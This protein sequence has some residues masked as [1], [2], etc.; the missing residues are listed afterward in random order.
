LVRKIRRR[1]WRRKRKSPRKKRRKMVKRAYIDAFFDE[2]E[3]LAFTVK[4]N[5][6]QWGKSKFETGLQT[7]KTRGTAGRAWDIM[8]ASR[9]S[10]DIPIT[11]KRIK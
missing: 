8:T 11:P 7:G 1:R 5:K 6:F 4:P 2:L 3:K 9:R 10:A